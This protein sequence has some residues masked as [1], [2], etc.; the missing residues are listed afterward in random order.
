MLITRGS[1]HD[2]VSI[3]IGTTKGTNGLNKLL[4]HR[5]NTNM[6]KLLQFFFSQEYIYL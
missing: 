1:Y 2:E 4:T 3:N 6:F 5:K